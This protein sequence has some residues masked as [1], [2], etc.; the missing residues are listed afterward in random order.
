MNKVNIMFPSLEKGIKKM[1]D[2]PERSPYNYVSVKNGHAIVVN[3][4]TI[5]CLN[6]ED[7]F[8]NYHVIEEEEKVGFRELMNW[9]EGKHFT[10]EFWGYLTSRNA[11]AVIDE[12]RI[13]VTGQMFEKELIY[14]ENDVNLEG[15]IN[16]LKKSFADNKNQVSITAIKNSQ[17]KIIDSCVGKLIS[18]N[19][20]I[21]ELNAEPTSM[22]KFTIEDMSCVFGITTNPNECTKR[23]F[24]FENFK[25]FVQS[26]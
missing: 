12:E 9:M 13:S 11:V 24:N 15:V 7:Y 8:L 6:M 14:H 18:Q 19:S 16:L 22:I 25:T 3:Q 2:A 17:L 20:L 1:K 21:F 10:S 5:I 4:Q 26:F 23:P